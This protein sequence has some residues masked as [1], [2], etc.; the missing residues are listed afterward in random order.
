MEVGWKERR[1]HA[2]DCDLKSFFDTVNHDR[3][4]QQLREKIKDRRVLALIRRYLQAGVVMPDGT[5]EA[6]PQGTTASSPSR[7]KHVRIRIKNRDTNQS[8]T[9]RIEGVDFIHRF[10]LHALPSGFHRIRYRGFLHARGKP[11]L[12]W[13]Q[14]ALDARLRKREKKPP[15]PQ[16]VYHCPRCGRPM[17]RKNKPSRAPPD[18][19][20]YHFLSTVAA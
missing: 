9:R 1:F 16:P 14:T 7:R 17:Q 18:E 10:L 11:A 12:E 15:S 3:L 13:L 5:R 6:T 8:E 19:R 4:M 20:N 2:V